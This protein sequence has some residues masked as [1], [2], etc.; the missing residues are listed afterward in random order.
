MTR[1]FIHSI[2]GLS[3]RDRFAALYDF[4]RRQVVPTGERVFSQCRACH[5]VGENAKNLVGPNLNG[6]FGRPAG[7][8]P[9]FNYSAA[10]KNSARSAILT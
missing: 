9:G 1:W 5:Q 4:W 10:S 6:L 7:S 3:G 2:E 8:V